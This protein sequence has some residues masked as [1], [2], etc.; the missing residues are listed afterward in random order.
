M[1]DASSPLSVVGV[2]SEPVK[3]LIVSIRKHRE[4]ELIQSRF[5]NAL[6]SEASAYLAAMNKM[7]AYGNERITPK[8]LEIKS[9]PTKR[10]ITE[11]MIMAS[12][13]PLF[14]KELLIAFINLA[15][16]CSEISENE[17]FMKSLQQIPEQ[18]DFIKRMA[19]IYVKDNTAAIN[20]AYFRYFKIYGKPVSSLE[21]YSQESAKIEEIRKSLVLIKKWGALARK[22]R[23]RL[24]RKIGL[25][26]LRN[27]ETLGKITVCVK[28]E[29]YS[30][31]DLNDYLPPALEP[32]L[33]LVDGIRYGIS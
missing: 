14:C 18:F 17:A 15:K 30:Y 33:S 29:A 32:L 11:V 25:R 6:E 7:S 1:S 19:A 13:I 16:A 26:F 3:A 8:L 5:V 9:I 23:V 10:Q 28:I 31:V 21:L 12:E 22:N 27:L 20:G 4:K 2:I 24:S